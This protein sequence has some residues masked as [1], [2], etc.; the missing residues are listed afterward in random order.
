MFLK[1]KKLESWVIDSDNE[2]EIN[3]KIREVTNQI[4][5]ILQC[6]NKKSELETELDNLRTE[7]KYFD[8]YDNLNLN[9]IIP[10]TY[11]R[12]VKSKQDF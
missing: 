2:D 7:K 1:K 6:K 4:N 5:E 11:R 12:L 9:K 8:D 3:Q 10:I